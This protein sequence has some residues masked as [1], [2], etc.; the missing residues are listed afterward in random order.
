MRHPTDNPI[1]SLRRPLKVL[2]EIFCKCLP[3]Y[4][5]RSLI[6]A[7]PG[8]TNQDVLRKI[9]TSS[10]QS[11]MMFRVFSW[12]RWWRTTEIWKRYIR[13]AFKPATLLK[14]DFFPVNIAK[15]LSAS[16]S[17]NIC[18]RILQFNTH[19]NNKWGHSLVRI[20]SPVLI[21]I[22]CKC[23]VSLIFSIFFFFSALSSICLV[24]DG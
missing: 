5:P 23:V 12:E 7:V 6:R 4:F 24:F 16:I 11:K 19:K 21:P 9:G 18:E 1:K 17:K 8:T 13:W 14:S 10:W 3:K 20:G 15:C 22:Q 2:R